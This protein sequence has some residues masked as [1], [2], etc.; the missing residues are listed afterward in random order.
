MLFLLVSS[1]TITLFLI[2]ILI[3]K[4][5]IM[6]INDT[7]FFKWPGQAH[8][9]GKGIRIR[10]RGSRLLSAVIYAHSRS[11]RSQMANKRRGRVTASANRFDFAHT[12][13]IHRLPAKESPK[14]R[15]MPYDR[16]SKMRWSCAN[17]V[18]EARR[19]RLNANNENLNLQMIWVIDVDEQWGKSHWNSW[20]KG[21]H[22]SAYLMKGPR[23]TV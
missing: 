1:M 7:L 21:F 12:W 4:I 13:L 6:K 19:R 11:L 8:Q 17:I 23:Q 18:N 5:M 2:Y 10:I 14:R 9:S 15:M 16:T 20:W 3:G 22:S